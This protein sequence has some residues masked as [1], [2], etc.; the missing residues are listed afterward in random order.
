MAKKNHDSDRRK[1]FVPPDVYN[2]DVIG[3]MS[4]EEIMSTSSRLEAERN[5]LINKG[6]DP[7]L[8]EVEI[9][10]LRREQQLRKLRSERHAE[11]IASRGNLD[12]DDVEVVHL[13]SRNSAMNPSQRDVN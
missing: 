7:Y 1:S 3:Y 5:S 10:Y 4:D 9:A 6:Q 13:D 8:C 11:Y 2:M 12:S